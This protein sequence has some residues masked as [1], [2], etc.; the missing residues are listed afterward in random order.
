MD[1][2]VG[3]VPGRAA[4]AERYLPEPAV[5]GTGIFQ[6]FVEIAKGA[7]S[8]AIAAVPFGSLLSNGAETGGT[9]SFSE[10]IALQIQAQQEMQVTSLVSNIERSKHESKMSAIRNIRVG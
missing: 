3:V 9:G 6:D 10:L 5:D 4:A 7:L 8:G 2:V 1:Q